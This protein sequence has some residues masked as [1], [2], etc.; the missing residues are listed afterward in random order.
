M[1]GISIIPPLNANRQFVS[2]HTCVLEPM[3]ASPVLRNAG[4]KAAR[5]SAKWVRSLT[6][7]MHACSAEVCS[8]LASL[9]VGTDDVM[10]GGYV[11]RVPDSIPA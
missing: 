2:L 7:A 9:E 10:E 8:A 11:W 6:E 5:D 3:K 4:G 1:K